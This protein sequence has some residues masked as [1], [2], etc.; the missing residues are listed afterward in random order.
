MQKREKKSMD[1]KFKYPTLHAIPVNDKSSNVDPDIDVSTSDEK[2]LEADQLSNEKVPQK[3]AEVNE[4]SMNKSESVE[5]NVEATHTDHST[6]GIEDQDLVNNIGN[7]SI[8]ADNNAAPPKTKKPKKK[9]KS[10]FIPKI[11]QVLRVLKRIFIGGTLVASIGATYLF[12]DQNGYI[13]MVTNSFKS[14]EDT[15]ELD[16]KQNELITKMQ[17]VISDLEKDITNLKKS[18]SNLESKLKEA[19]ILRGNISTGITDF[20]GEYNHYKEYSTGILNENM[21]RSTNNLKYVEELKLASLK[22][23]NSNAENS[24]IVKALQVKIDSVLSQVN[25]VKDKTNKIESK[26]NS[27][28][29]RAATKSVKSTPVVITGP[30]SI[31][32]YSGLKLAQIFHWSTQKI[33]VLSD[34]AGTSI[35]VSKG[36]KLGNATIT[37]ITDSYVYIR[38]DLTSDI[39]KLVKGG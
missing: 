39:Y 13:E 29:R 24:I 18:N 1:E 25:S 22:S 4:E 17:L 7:E 38:D 16:V 3:R 19:A 34:S 31:N 37:E 9:N 10:T 5:A 8:E 15:S 36:N 23:I 6:G 14:G 32:S 21:N 12:A 28:P 11:M 33:A 30:I 35:Q 2:E 26:F 20:K 27:T